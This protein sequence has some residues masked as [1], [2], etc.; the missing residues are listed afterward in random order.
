MEKEREHLFL[1]AGK[2]GVNEIKYSTEITETEITSTSL[3]TQV[4]NVTGTITHKKTETKKEGMGGSEKYENRGASVYVDDKHDI[5]KVEED[6]QKLSCMTTVFSYEFYKECPKLVS[7]V[8]K[9]C[10]FRMSKVEYYI[11]SE[12]ISELSLAVKAYFNEYGLGVSFG[13]ILLA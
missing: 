9:R 1:L 6:L 5:K 4:A 8:L 11:E 13:R 12:D 7:F 2:L 3:D 10:S